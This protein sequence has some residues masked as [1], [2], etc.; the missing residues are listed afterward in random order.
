MIE[1]LLKSKS[2]Y[3]DSQILYHYV[4]NK[5]SAIN[6]KNTMQRIIDN[7]TS[8]LDIQNMIENSNLQNKDLKQELNNRITNSLN[9]FCIQTLQ[10]KNYEQYVQ[11][12]ENDKK[13]NLLKY[14]KDIIKFLDKVYKATY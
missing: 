5:N 2:I 14:R 12:I 9:M 13:K 8:C 3:I 4:Y 6:G 10:D 11:E 1:T 7:I